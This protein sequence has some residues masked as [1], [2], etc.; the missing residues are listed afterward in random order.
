MMKDSKYYKK[1][2]KKQ[3]KDDER[4][5]IL[6]SKLLLAVIFVLGSLVLTNF[7]SSLKDKYVKEVLEKNIDIS[8]INKF[9]NKY[10]G[11]GKK[12]EEEVLV[13]NLDSSKEYEKVGESV[14]FTMEAE[15]PITTLEGGII[16]FIG[17]KD[18]LGNTVIVQGNNGVDIWYSNIL[19]TDY[20][21]YDYISKG[22]KLGVSMS[23]NYLVTIKKDDKTLEYEEYIS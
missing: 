21:L 10:I 2:L 20:S 5:S 3:G 15:E 13:A 11:R 7:S 8:Y 4:L 9:Y 16:V 6:F 14:K 1:K 12:E 19:M 23:D 22:D 17:D 18:D